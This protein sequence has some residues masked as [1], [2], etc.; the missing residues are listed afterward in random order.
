M[1]AELKNVPLCDTQW[2]LI[3]DCCG[4]LFIY[5]STVCRY[6]QNAHENRSLNEAVV[7]VTSSGSGPET[8]NMIDDLYSTVLDAANNST[9]MNN[10]DKQRMN[11]VLQTVVC[12]MEPM[13]VDV[14]ASLL[15]LESGDRVYRLLAPLRSVLNVTK[16]TGIVTTLHASFA[17]FMLSTG[18]SAKFHCQASIRH[19]KMAEACLQVIEASKRKFNVCALP[20]SYLL[21]HEVEGLEEKK[22]QSISAELV[23]ACRHWSGHLSLSQGSPGLIN[24]VHHFYS[25]RLLLWMEIINLTKKMRYATLTMQGA[26]KWCIV[27]TCACISLVI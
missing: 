12:A 23:Y 3:V 13:C 26:E 15:G 16:G 14:I 11:E 19:T 21:D 9:E 8:E 20:S 24:C 17:D 2:P 4:E 6:V 5:A 25:A 18:R 10:T 27:G 7:V 22:S 1:R